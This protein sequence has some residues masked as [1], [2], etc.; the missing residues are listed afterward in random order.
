M[1][2]WRA[3]KNRFPPMLKNMQSN[4]HFLKKKSRKGLL[5]CSIF[6]PQSDPHGPILFCLNR[7]FLVS[8]ASS[9]RHTLFILSP[10]LLSDLLAKRRANEKSIFFWVE[11][12]PALRVQVQKKFQKPT[13]SFPFC[14][15]VRSALRVAKSHVRLFPTTFKSCSR[16]KP[17]VLVNHA[18]AAGFFGFNSAQRL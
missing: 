17:N 10:A 12:S 7:S 16:A 11:A 3:R 2:Q 14:I 15:S 5:I 18:E 4:I 1:E 13:N 6:H 8:A 9:F